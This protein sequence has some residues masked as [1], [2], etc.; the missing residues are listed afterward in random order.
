MIAW[1]LDCV[2]ALGSPVE[3][4]N[5]GPLLLGIEQE[6]VPL[7]SIEIVQ[8]CLFGS[9][10]WTPVVGDLTLDRRVDLDDARWFVR[11]MSGPGLQPP[12]DLLLERPVPVPEP[13]GDCQAQCLLVGWPDVPVAAA[14]WLA[15]FD[16]DGDVDVA[17]FARFQNAL[18]PDL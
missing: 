16:D 17:D 5:P 18:A 12:T 6:P 11:C 9:E 10:R 1:L 4:R 8:M 3:Y 15:D 14:C 2:L 13:T 7:E